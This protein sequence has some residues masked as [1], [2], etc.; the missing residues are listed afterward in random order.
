MLV[1]YETPLED[2]DDGEAD[3]EGEA[4]SKEWAKDVATNQKGC[5]ASMY[6]VAEVEEMDLLSMYLEVHQVLVCPPLHGVEVYL[7]WRVTLFGRM[8]DMYVCP[9]EPSKY[10]W[11]KPFEHKMESANLVIFKLMQHLTIC[12]ERKEV[13]HYCACVCVCV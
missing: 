11:R 8:T 13:R 4:V 3:G 7:F 2:V 10:T 5:Y 1:E 12:N 6:S 9:V